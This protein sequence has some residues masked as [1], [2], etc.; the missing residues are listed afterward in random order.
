MNVKKRIMP[1]KQ[2]LFFNI[3]YSQT[4]SA[5]SNIKNITE[6]ISF[7]LSSKFNLKTYGYNKRE[8][9]Y[10]GKKMDKNFCYLYFNIKICELNVSSCEIVITS[11][12]DTNNEFKNFV[13]AFYSRIYA[14]N[15]LKY[16]E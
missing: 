14:Y 13:N 11:L 12:I 10:W 2:N 7:L 3:I 5:N 6:I 1:S 4:I 8:N 16:T 9:E 15:I